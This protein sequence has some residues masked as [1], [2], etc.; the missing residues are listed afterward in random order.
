MSALYLGS[1]VALRQ[2]QVETWE[3]DGRRYVIIPAAARVLYY[4]YRPVMYA[5]QAATGMRFHIGP[6]RE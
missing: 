3:H 1:Y 4:L 2:T 5:D 6:H